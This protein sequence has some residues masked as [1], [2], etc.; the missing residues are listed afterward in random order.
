MLRRTVAMGFVAAALLPTWVMAQPTTEEKIDALSAEI[1]A[2]RQQVSKTGGHG[3][4]TGKTT[5]AGYGELHFNNLENTRN[6]ANKDVID[7]HRFVLFF[8][9]AFSDRIRFHSELELE[10]AL[11]KDNNN[12]SGDKAPGEV[13]LEQAYLEFDINSRLTMKGGL[14]LVPVGI[15]NETHEPTTFYGVER[16]PIEKDILPATWWEAGAMASTK[17]GGGLSADFSVHSGLKVGSN[18]KVRDGRQ[19]VAEALANDP[20][21]T[22]RLK[23]S[24]P[25]VEWAA[26][27]QY[28]KDIG[29]GLVGDLG[30]ANLYESHVV[31]GKGPFGL[32]ALYAQWRL[33]GNAPAAAGADKQYGYYVEPA[34]K[35]NPKFGVFARYNQWDTKAG[36]NT[37]SDIRQIDVGVNYWP[38]ENVVIKADVQNQKAPNASTDEFDGFNLGI[39]YM[40]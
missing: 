25:G 14:F 35:I 23:W 19:K 22:A 24:I 18:F 3:Q 29:Q 8:G 28:Q 20:A 7:F 33:A 2:L 16:N 11:V 27:Y 1:E 12:G 40:F 21:Y 4:S 26:S 9:H 5:V 31:I 32:R 15:I 6:G 30:R 39:G 36:D 10:H 17:L 38:H 37:K 13:E 34:F